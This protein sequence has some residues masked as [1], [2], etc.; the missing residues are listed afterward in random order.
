MQGTTVVARGTSTVT[1]G[2]LGN[3]LVATA[4]LG[5]AVV[6]S[7]LAILAPILLLVL[8]TLFLFVFGR[9]ILSKPNKTVGA[10]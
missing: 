3:P 9:K 2:G 4:E 5:G 8:L 10:T 6:T 7:I 1:T